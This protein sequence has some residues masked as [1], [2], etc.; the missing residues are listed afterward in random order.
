M[1]NKKLV[2]R[3][4]TLIAL[5][6][7][8][9]GCK[10]D[11]EPITNI[12]PK[13]EEKETPVQKINPFSYE[14]IKKAKL[15]IAA[16]HPENNAKGA[17]DNDANKLYTYLK[18][19]PGKVSGEVLKQLEA[20]TSIKILDFPF[21]NAE[22][23]N[24]AFGLDE[25]KA[26]LLADG[27]L[28]AVVK[29]STQTETLLRG[30]VISATQLDVLYLPEETDTT[31]QFQAFLEAGYTQTQLNALKVCLFKRPRGYVRYLDKE[32]GRL[33]NVG[34]MQVWGLVFGIPLH[35][36]TDNNGFYNFPWRFNVGTI[37]GTQAKNPRVNIK[38]FN[39]QGAWVA[40]LP[41][42]FI[43]G[44]I[45]IHGWVGS[46][47]MRDEVNFEFTE[48]KQNRLW[49]QLM[50]GV[51]LFDQYAA[52]DNITSAPRALTIYAHWA[53]KPKTSSAPM[54]GHLA[55]LNI[56]IISLQYLAD[57]LGA[58]SP[59]DFPNIFNLLTGILPDITIRV[60]GNDDQTRS[61]SARLMLTCF[62][63]LGHASHF[64]RAG[65]A[66]WYDFMRATLRKHPDS[67][68][69]GGYGCGQNADDGN[70]AIGESWAEFIGTNYA[71]RLHPNGEKISRWAGSTP[72]NSWGSRFINNVDALEIEE[73]YANTWI[74]CGIYN[75]LMDVVNT[76]NEPWDV[77][78]GL[79]IQQL[80]EA[81][82]PN[83]DNFC[84]YK[85]QIFTRYGLNDLALGQI[86]INNNAF[87]GCL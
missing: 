68:C 43:V 48:H 30:S 72:P 3:W 56:G 35:T 47:A 31:L 34:G 22:V 66:Y 85:W 11:A 36:Y 28:Y 42:Q 45:H 23:Y 70:V 16:A 49:A 44:S 18:F 8:L 14:N 33:R 82:G 65:Q 5:F 41:V 51:N 54:L 87:H 60:N 84:A 9:A 7:N 15:K 32:T 13:L 6:I 67:Q 83:I 39:T 46:C 1:Q 55:G 71:I 59:N 19:N 37:M 38:P 2:F 78:G 81:L 50:D 20:D 25:N 74:S 80:Y 52:N 17:G 79:T 77:T 24:E 4:L 27:S 76:A 69:G 73:W 10:K 61:Y 57:L 53:D 26:K 29:K 63:E 75:D 58:S 12:E 21:A 86:F 40:T 62:H 64:Q